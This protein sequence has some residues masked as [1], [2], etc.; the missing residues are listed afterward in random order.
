MII[1]YVFIIA[2]FLSSPLKAISIDED[3]KFH[4]ILSQSQIYIDKTK[5][6]K[7]KDLINTKNSFKDNYEKSLSYGYAPGFNVWIKFTLHNTSNK[8]LHKILEYANPL[9]TDINFYIPEDKYVQEEGLF[10]IKQDRKTINP[11]FKLTLQ[12]Q[13]S[14][15]YYLQVRS[16]ITTLI[17][18]LKLYKLETFYEKEI[19]HQFF[20]ALFFASL[21]ILGVYNL[22]I[23]IFTKDISYLYYVLYLFGM[24]FHHF[25]YIGLANIYFLSQASIIFLL[26]I[27]SFIVALPV[28]FLALFTQSFIRLQQYKKLNKFL[29]LYLIILPFILVLVMFFDIFS[30]YRN[31]AIILLLLY[32]VLVTLYATFKKN[33]Q[34]YFLL[35]GWVMI[36][37]AVTLM[38]LSSIG[39]L[40]IHTNQS[41]FVEIALV[42]EAVIF[43]I[44]LAHRIKQLQIAKDKASEELAYQ[45]ENENEILLVKVE[46]KTNDLNNSL[47]EK[48]MLLK[49]LNHR[50]K[51]NMQ[52]IISLI[53]LQLDDIDD[54]YVKDILSTTH[55]RITAMSHLH[56]LLYYETNISNVN[57]S[58]YFILLIDEIQ[59][60]Y[61]KDIKIHLNIYCELKIDHAVYC[62]LIVNELATNA[63]KYAFKENTGDIYITLSLKENYYLLSI[64]DTGVGYT[65]KVSTHSL[66]LLLVKSLVKSK[67]KGE[68]STE[69]EDGVKVEIKWKDK[70]E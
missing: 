54:I 68:I 9:T 45:Q 41:Y 3:T 59:E 65:K 46:E 62:G 24:I 44:A 58:E 37:T 14:K 48:E 29:N 38:Y 21:L 43:S 63:F 31:I 2:L 56:D 53:R 27:A 60:S 66:G 39:F 42:L 61:S 10:H 13:E 25:I 28:F 26:Q 16:Q 51:N 5:T 11:I 64:R 18:K 69:S 23:Y 67:L 30:S 8:T 52:T 20:L 4:D 33:R 50:V 47:N 57:V 34:A 19:Q 22:F 17:V 36:L 6:L 35:F 15:T 32:L 49:E 55:N 12:A 1:K 7:L 40:D 70:Y